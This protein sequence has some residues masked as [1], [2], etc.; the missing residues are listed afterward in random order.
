MHGDIVAAMPRWL[1]ALSDV[2]SL[3]LRL[4]CPDAGN[5]RSDCLA[6]SLFF[7]SLLLWK[8]QGKPPKRA[9]IFSR[10]GT[11]K[12]PG[13]EG[14]NAQKS[15]EI[16]CNEKARKSKKA[17]KGRSGQEFPTLASRKRCDFENAETLQ[18]EIAPPRN[19]GD[20]LFLEVWAPSTCSCCLKGK[21]TAIWNLRFRNSAICDF[22]PRFFCGTC[23]KSCD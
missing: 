8:K 2:L 21:N 7:L 12:I 16:P 9:R 4:Q 13:K 11:P 3:R 23:G 15:K 10:C 20:F 19:H 14:K 1:R 22:I 18:F 6:I 17:R 5:N